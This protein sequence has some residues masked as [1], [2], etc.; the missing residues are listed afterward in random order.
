L[1]NTAGPSSYRERTVDEYGGTVLDM[2]HT[3][4]ELKVTVT[5]KQEQVE[6]LKIIAPEGSTGGS[7]VWYLGRK[8]GGK[9]TDHAQELTLTP[10]NTNA[11][12]I[13]SIKFWKAVILDGFER[14][15]SW[16]DDSNYEVTFTILPDT[17]KDDGKTL[18][19]IEYS[20]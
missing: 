5:L 13:S 8:P 10:L 7:T 1:T 11:T 19:Y 2:I 12:P 14:T 16:E 9:A 6:L 18:G 4:E 17:S 3:G 20:S 15:F